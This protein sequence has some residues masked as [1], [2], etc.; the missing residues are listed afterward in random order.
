M[1]F[2]AAKNQT[3]QSLTNLLVGFFGVLAAFLLLP[4]TLKFAV[5]RFL[6]G[7]VKEVLLV[8]VTGLLTEKLVGV[9]GHDDNRESEKRS[10]PET[11]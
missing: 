8:L 6:I 11:L 2:G 3:R 1:L 4:K 10:G 9:I 5:R 7:I